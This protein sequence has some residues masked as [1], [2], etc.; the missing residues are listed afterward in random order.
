MTAAAGPGAPATGSALRRELGPLDGT[1][2]A[3]NSTI[4]GGI[5][6]TPGWIAASLGSP[7][8]ILGAWVFG[9]VVALLG[10]LLSAELASRFPAAGGAY[11]YIREAF[12]RFWAFFSHWAYLLIA[13]AGSTAAL[14]VVLGEY[15]DG[16]LGAGGRMARPLALLILGLIGALL[17][18]GLKASAWS[19][20]IV[21]AAKLAGLL[22]V[23]ALAFLLE[24]SFAPER[25][26]APA[27][28]SPSLLLG[29]AVAFQ[30]IFY[31]YDG[32]ADVGRVAGEVRDPR[33][34]LPRIFAGGVL[35]C[36]AIYLAVN[37]AYLHVLTP[38]EMAGTPLVAADVAE[39]LLGAGGRALIVGL[40]FV[41]LF[42]VLQSTLFTL[43]RIAYAMARD[44]LLPKVA[45]GVTA[46]GAPLPALGLIVGLAAAFVLLG[47]FEKLVAMVS[48]TRFLV[49]GLLAAAA[50]RLRRS[51][52]PHAYRAPGF[53]WTA[54]LFL[55]IAAAFVLATLWSSPREAGAGLA[56]LALGW[57]IYRLLGPRDV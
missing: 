19:Q 34:N 11:V 22:G 12:G 39:R 54:S 2:I 23:V 49:Y 25:G 1:A 13:E 21:T 5:F 45:S 41:S 44:Q 18:L 52:P 26:A 46:A 38:A 8:L 51:A 17:G 53:P 27:P 43:A 57:P 15:A 42:G 36:A 56:L 6:R 55:L 3:I 48:F 16:A 40:A 10:A 29:L 50:L 7:A 30:G 31:S 47:T 4:G 14:A 20:N 33:R 9:G 32:W 37:A 35:S 24:P 28:A